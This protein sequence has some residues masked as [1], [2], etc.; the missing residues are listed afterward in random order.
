ML[1]PELLAKLREQAGKAETCPVCGY[2]PV[3]VIRGQF[4]EIYA[5]HTPACRTRPAL[6]V[7]PGGEPA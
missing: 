7:V 1:T 6:R 3:L 2:D 4:V 5:A